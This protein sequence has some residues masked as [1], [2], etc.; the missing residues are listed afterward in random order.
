MGNSVSRA[1]TKLPAL[2]MPNCADA[3]LAQGA[4]D[5]EAPGAGAHGEAVE[6]DQ[7]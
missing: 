7:P 2:K 4:L 6:E 5:S 3:Q 1:A